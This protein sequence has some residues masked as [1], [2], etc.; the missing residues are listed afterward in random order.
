MGTV[1]LR[2]ES[3]FGVSQGLEWSQNLERQLGQFCLKKAA[4]SHYVFDLFTLSSLVHRIE[5]ITNFG[6]LLTYN[7]CE[8]CSYVRFPERGEG[9]ESWA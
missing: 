9:G 6:P 2:V 5:F 4:N 7:Q 1:F 8:K 3:S